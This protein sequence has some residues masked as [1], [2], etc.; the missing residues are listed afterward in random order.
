MSVVPPPLVS[1]GM[2]AAFV[3]STP[4]SYTTSW[5]FE[6]PWSKPRSIVSYVSLIDVDVGVNRVSR[7][8]TL[9]PPVMTSTPAWPAALTFALSPID[10]WVFFVT[11]GTAAAAPTAAVPP[12]PILPPM[13]SILSCSSDETRTLPWALT[14]A[15]S[16][17][18]KFP[19]ID[20]VVVMS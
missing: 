12:P 9:N 7:G 18:E 2:L 11:T 14:A 5:P 4:L 8:S 19:T 20:A 3:V 10:A 6:N 15:L 13:T 1:A 16:L 17:G